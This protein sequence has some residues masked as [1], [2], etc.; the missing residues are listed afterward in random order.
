[1]YTFKNKF[2]KIPLGETCF[3]ILRLYG[4][5]EGDPVL[6]LEPSCDPFQLMR[7]S[8]GDF[9]GTFEKRDIIFWPRFLA[10]WT[11]QAEGDGGVPATSFGDIA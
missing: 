10:I 4:P 8:Y 1:M 6:C 9:S 5:R 2:V 11:M 7:I 3:P